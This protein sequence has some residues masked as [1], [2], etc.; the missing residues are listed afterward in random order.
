[1][2]EAYGGRARRLSHAPAEPLRQHVSNECTS[3]PPVRLVVTEDDCGVRLVPDDQLTAFASRLVP[4]P[5]DK[6]TVRNRRQALEDAVTRAL[7]GAGF[8]ESGSWSHGT[9]VAG[10]SDVDYMALFRDDQKPLRPST[11]LSKLKDVLS[12]AHWGVVSC[13]VSS[14]TVKVQFFSAPH[15]EIVPAYFKRKVGDEFLLDI[16]GPAD[17]WVESAPLAHNRFVTSVNTD[18]QGKVKPLVRLVKAWKYYQQVPVSSFYLEMRTAK[19]A[20]G[21]TTILYGIDLVR[22]FRELTDCEMR[23]MND[24]VGLVSRIPATSSDEN[25]RRALRLAGEAYRV[26]EEA[27]AALDAQDASGYWWKMKD[28]FGS[29]FPYPIW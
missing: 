16:P 15:F 14:P 4:E 27:R 9:A 11:A 2:A 24:P 7:G 17:D 3:A 18:L 8:V 13:R 6:T 28:V 22:V 26:L 23:S 20:S 19:Y 10:N 12:D 29:D 5:W 21:E 1:M 25:R